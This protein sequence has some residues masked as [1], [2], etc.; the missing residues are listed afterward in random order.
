MWT[1]YSK[2]SDHWV[3][4]QTIASF[5]RMREFEPLGADWVAN[6]LQLSDFLEVDGSKTNVRRK[7]EVTEPKGQSQRSIYAVRSLIISMYFFTF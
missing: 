2:D 1:L 7:T 6:A 3:P 4:I 5:K